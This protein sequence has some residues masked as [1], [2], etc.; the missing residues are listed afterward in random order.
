MRKDATA[1]GMAMIGLVRGFRDK[2][3]FMDSRS[4]RESRSFRPTDERL[5]SRLVLS[6][7]VSVPA[8][9]KAILDAA[10]TTTTTTTGITASGQATT[11][12]V[13]TT[14]ATKTKDLGAVTI[15]KF[16]TAGNDAVILGSP[17]STTSFGDSDTV[18]ADAVV[19]GSTVGSGAVIG[20]KAYISN[21]TIP[22]G[23]VIPNGSIILS[24]QIV[25]TVQW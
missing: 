20:N 7:H 10:G 19:S 12:T 2:G 14:I 1:S 9:V 15:G 3:I 21:S 4:R 23:A 11:G 25:G 24:N 17:T 22:A 6:S 5:E 18:G 16:F 13:T 8:E